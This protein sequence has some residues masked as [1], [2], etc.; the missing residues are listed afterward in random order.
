M[1]NYIYSAKFA[2][3][4]LLVGRTGCGKTYF[5]QKV[6]VNRFFG[7]LK[8]VEWVSYTELKR[9]REAEIESCFSCDV[10]FH[11]PKGLQKFED[12]LEDFNCCSNTAKVIDDDTYSSDEEDIVNSSFGEKTNCDRL[13]VMDDVSGL[14]GKSKNL[15]V[16]QQ[17]HVN[18]ITHAFTFFTLSIRK[19]L[20]G[21]QF[22]HKR[23]FLTSFKQVSLF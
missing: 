13:I 7:R 1:Q 19:N 15:Q 17:L 4:I 16:F 5:T 6:A 14:T 8:K 21:E 3:S 2:G 23:I 12:L 11:Y 9:E 10:E 22:F 20:S 18:L